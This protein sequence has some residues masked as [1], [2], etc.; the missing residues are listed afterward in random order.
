MLSAGGAYITLS[1]MCAG[2][3]ADN[4]ATRPA[5]FTAALVFLI[6]LLG[7]QRKGKVR[8]N[9]EQVTGDSHRAIDASGQRVFGTSIH[10]I[11]GPLIHRGIFVEPRI[12]SRESR[13][14]RGQEAEGGRVTYRVRKSEW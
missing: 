12:P 1:A 7:G 10:R 6:Q 8:G 9:R 11:I 2:G 4:H 14:S 3:P 13:K 5:R